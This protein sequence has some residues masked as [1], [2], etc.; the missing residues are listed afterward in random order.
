MT[1]HA[2]AAAL[3]QESFATMDRNYAKVE[4]V[5]AQSR[6]ISVLTGENSAS[7]HNGEE[8]QEHK[9][10]N[11]QLCNLPEFSPKSPGRKSSK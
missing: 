5:T 3:G 7:N 11:N 9:N 10:L 2:V 6:T 1:S 4:A 8:A